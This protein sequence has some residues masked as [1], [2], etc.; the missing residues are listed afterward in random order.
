MPLESIARLITQFDKQEIRELFKKA[1][2]MI[3]SQGLEI[4][5]APQIL[6]YS[7]ILIV[8]PRKAG[9]AVERNRIRRRLKSIFFEEK[10]FE[11]PFDCIVLV[12]KPAIQ[13]SFDELKQLLKQAYKID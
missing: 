7:R 4:R 13:L 10:L 6:D 12:R 1:Q 3:K 8:T 2:P 9:N 5:L 11:Q